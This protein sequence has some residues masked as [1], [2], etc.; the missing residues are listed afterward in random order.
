M[1]LSRDYGSAICQQGYFYYVDP[2]GTIVEL[3][4]PSELS[5]NPCA[6]W[7]ADN[8]WFMGMRGG[9]WTIGHIDPA[10]TINW[11]PSSASASPMTILV[12]D[13]GAGGVFFTGGG[14][15]MDITRF[16]ISGEVYSQSFDSAGLGANYCGALHNG[17]IYFAEE[18]VVLRKCGIDDWGNFIDATISF[19][20]NYMS[21]GVRVFDDAIYIL[22]LA[23]DG[24]PQG[25]IF[26]VNHAMDSIETF[27]TTII[28]PSPTDIVFTDTF[29]AVLDFSGISFLDLDGTFNFHIPLGGCPPFNLRR[30][31]D[32]VLYMSPDSENLALYNSDGSYIQ[33]APMF[34]GGTGLL[35]GGPAVPPPSG[36]PLDPPREGMFALAVYSVPIDNP[37]LLR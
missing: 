1:S 11:F 8:F 33:F 15:T 12:D 20:G 9:N 3:L 28:G 6:A 5:A 35:E 17:E 31:G 32:A 13:T 30:I 34:P 37:G 27:A 36:G 14:L 10:G 4:D 26:K 29:C 24:A 23:L 16:D 2:A 7:W 18:T 25:T 21:C 22:A 19:P